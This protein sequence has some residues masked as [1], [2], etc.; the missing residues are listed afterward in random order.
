MPRKSKIYSSESD[1]EQ[2]YL[3][4]INYIK[5]LGINT[6]AVHWTN[7]NTSKWRDIK[8][9][10]DKLFKL[11]LCTEPGDIVQ[12]VCRAGQCCNPLH[13]AV[14]HVE[15]LSNLENLDM[16]EIEELAEMIEVNLLQKMGFSGYF[17]HFNFGNPLPA[18]IHN[19]YTACNIALKRKHKRLLPATV[20]GKRFRRRLCVKMK[21]N[22]NLASIEKDISG[23]S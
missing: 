11:N 15:E 6:K 17:K 23:K 16:L 4:Y 5:S 12:R 21:E 9:N 18:E 10:L 3:D 20:I 14:V 8:R 1:I 22:L 2:A 13:Y 19:F 7:P